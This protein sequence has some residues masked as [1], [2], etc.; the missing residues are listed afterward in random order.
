MERI[1]LALQAPTPSKISFRCE[2]CHDSGQQ[3][4]PV[5]RASRRCQCRVEAARRKAL[6]A[7]PSRFT[8]AR[9]GTLAARAD[10]HPKQ[11]AILA[12]LREQP[13][14]SYVFAGANGVGKTHLGWALYAEAVERGLNVRA[15]SLRELLAQY[16]RAEQFPNDRP[17]VLPKDLKSGRWFLFLDE[18]EKAR[19][20]EYAAEMFFDL[21]DAA[22][23]HNQQIVVTS[24][25]PA[26]SIPEYSGTTLREHW[27]RADEVWGNSIVRRLQEATWVN[28][29]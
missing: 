22:Y 26:D 21:L 4:D 23:S 5:T 27:G 8:G 15:V 1:N 20:S 17:V 28:M 9:L 29:F 3:Y 6:D 2:I 25:M 10:L 7:I 12:R 16:R 24:N 18:A 13:G 11:P 19:P 14:K